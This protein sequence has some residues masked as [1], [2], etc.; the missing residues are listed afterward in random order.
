[1]SK[2]ELLIGAGS[3]HRKKL[4]LDGSTEF[5][6]LTTLDNNPDHDVDVVWDLNAQTPLPFENESFDEIHAYEVLEHLGSQ[7]DYKFFFR[8]FEEYWRI[9]KPD[10]HFY[11]TVPSPESAWA[12]GDPSHTRIFHPYWLTFLNQQNYEE[13]VGETAMSDFR[14][15]YHANFI[16]LTG[17]VREDSFI[18]VLRKEEASRG[19]ITNI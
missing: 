5:E 1:M 4:S 19:I 7:G 3:D 13:Q 2:T 12:L 16:A 18:F 10:G 6:N 17:E 9:L 11:A 15:I 8:E 14:S